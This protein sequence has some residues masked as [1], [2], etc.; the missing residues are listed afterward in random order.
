MGSA[1]AQF[2][3]HGEHP[4]IRAQSL[5][6]PHHA[7]TLMTQ[8]RCMDVEA[9]VRTVVVPVVGIHDSVGSTR[10]SDFWCHS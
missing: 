3:A 2:D 10:E 4:S 8:E 9:E 1:D 6:D 7:A 5:S